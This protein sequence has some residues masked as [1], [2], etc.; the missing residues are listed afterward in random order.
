M[1]RD[2]LV[3]TRDQL[4]KIVRT[5]WLA[6]VAEQPDPSP[7]WRLTWDESSEEAREVDRRIGERL[8]LAGQRSAVTAIAQ[9]HASVIGVAR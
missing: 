9:I 7:W 8:F 3:M 6:W 2:Q 4:G 5:E 1:T